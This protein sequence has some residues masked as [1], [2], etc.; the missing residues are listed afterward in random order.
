M[1]GATNIIGVFKPRRSS[2][3]GSLVTQSAPLTTTQSPLPPP[4]PA[5]SLVHVPQISNFVDGSPPITSE[6]PS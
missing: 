4:M 3:L 6:G 5:A 1:H 2:G